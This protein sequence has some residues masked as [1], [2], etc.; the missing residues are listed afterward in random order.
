MLEC[1]AEALE[2]WE[3]SYTKVPALREGGCATTHQRTLWGPGG[4]RT[5][6]EGQPLELHA[7]RDI[8]EMKPWRFVTWSRAGPS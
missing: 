7:C 8:G 5:G 3:A 6:V 2:A 1:R 4:Q